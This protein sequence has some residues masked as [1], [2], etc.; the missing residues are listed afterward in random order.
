MICFFVKPQDT[1]RR[2]C[3]GTDIANVLQ[4]CLFFFNQKLFTL[5]LWPDRQSL[6]F[7]WG[8]SIVSSVWTS[9]LLAEIIIKAESWVFFHFL[10]EIN[11]GWNLSF[12]LF[13]GWNKNK[14]WNLSFIFSWLINKGWNLSF[15]AEIT[16]LKL[17]CYRQDGIVLDDRSGV[18]NE[19]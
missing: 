8:L 4:T 12:L 5:P 14:G 15:L 7:I 9:D 11:K 2:D 1:P 3:F 18:I 10:A 16:C 13:S 17:H 6:D 19:V